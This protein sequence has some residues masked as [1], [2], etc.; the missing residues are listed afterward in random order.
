LEWEKGIHLNLFYL[1]FINYSVFQFAWGSNK[2]F[3]TFV[4]ESMVSE[5]CADQRKCRWG[6]GSDVGQNR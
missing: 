4:S 2:I 3:K 5:G 6:L 1:F